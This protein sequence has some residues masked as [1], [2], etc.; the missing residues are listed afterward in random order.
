MQRLWRISWSFVRREDLREGC[1]TNQNLWR[2]L[3][4]TRFHKVFVDI[5]GFEQTVIDHQIVIHEGELAL[6]LTI[7]SIQWRTP[8]RH[9][10]TREAQRPGCTIRNLLYD[11]PR[12]DSGAV[13]VLGWGCVGRHHDQ[14]ARP[15]S[16]W[17][18]IS[19]EAIVRR[20]V[21]V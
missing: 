14:S 11:A 16:K 10:D 2:A 6:F 18:H 13:Q 21:L 7:Q 12:Q 4:M 20:M 15:P 1:D 9:V 19:F 8:L 3:Q 17:R 5:V